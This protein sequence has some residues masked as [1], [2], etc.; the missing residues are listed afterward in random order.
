MGF[1]SP[2]VYESSLGGQ[3]CQQVLTAEFPPLEASIRELDFRSPPVRQF[4]RLSALSSSKCS[5]YRLK[6]L[7]RNVFTPLSTD[8]TVRQHR[9]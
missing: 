2:Q 4:E 8:A 9:R 3:C 1:A 7:K 6:S 5:T